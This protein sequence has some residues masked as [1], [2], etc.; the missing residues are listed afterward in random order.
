MLDKD[1]IEKHFSHFL[2]TSLVHLQF[3]FVLHY[4]LRILCHYL[5][6]FTHVI[7]LLLMLPVCVKFIPQFNFVHLHLITLLL[8]CL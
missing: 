4:L 5:F 6:H 2:S 1:H 3:L 8:K 7:V